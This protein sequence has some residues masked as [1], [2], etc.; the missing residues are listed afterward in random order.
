MNALV[1][2]SYRIIKQGQRTCILGQDQGHKTKQ[3]KELGQSLNVNYIKELRVN[4]SKSKGTNQAV[5]RE[6]VEK[7]G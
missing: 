3:V 7:Q 6:Y 4:R 1:H 2:F 5:I